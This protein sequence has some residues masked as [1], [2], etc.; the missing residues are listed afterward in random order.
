MTGY[1]ESA[2]DL[3]GTRSTSGVIR[4]ATRSQ[5]RAVDT[6]EFGLRRQERFLLVTGGRGVGKTV[7]CRALVERLAR[8]G[9]VSCLTN[10]PLTTV[11]LYRRLLDDFAATSGEADRLAPV[12][13]DTAAAHYERLLAFLDSLPRR[14]RSPVVLVD[15]ANMLPPAIVDKLLAVSSLDAYRQYPLQLVLV[16]R[17]VSDASAALGIASLDDRVSTRTR[18]LPMSVDECTE[19]VA[20]R[21]VP[22]PGHASFTREAVAA[23]H[24]ITDGLP[25]LVNRLLERSIQQDGARQVDAADVRAAAASLQLATRPIPFRWLARLAS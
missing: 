17:P 10:P 20:Q 16:G 9:P 13:E 2:L 19:H 15:D 24:E 14:R 21:T 8:R 11:A 6:L 3:V 1:L 12:R 18:L 25:G 7:L 5:S 22:T 4:R 23:L